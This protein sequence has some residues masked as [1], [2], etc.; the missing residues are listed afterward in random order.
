MEIYKH[1]KR[2]LSPAIMVEVFKVTIIVII[3]RCQDILF[4]RIIQVGDAAIFD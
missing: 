3:S 1:I 2:G 4:I